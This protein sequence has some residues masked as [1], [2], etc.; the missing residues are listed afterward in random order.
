MPALKVQE[1]PIPPGEADGA[2]ALQRRLQ[3]LLRFGGA[4]IGQ[5]RKEFLAAD[6]ADAVA[7]AQALAQHR[8]QRA[9]DQV[10]RAGARARR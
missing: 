5:H 9:D 10:A 1:K 3:D 4:A 6:A 2:E 8:R 7:R